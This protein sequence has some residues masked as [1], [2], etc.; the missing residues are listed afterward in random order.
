MRLQGNRAPQLRGRPVAI[1]LKQRESVC[2]AYF[3]ATCS[4]IQMSGVLLASTAMGL[5]AA[6]LSD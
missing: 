1:R 2:S 5:T 6:G 3:E 4:G